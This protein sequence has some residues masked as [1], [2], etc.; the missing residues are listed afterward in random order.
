[1]LAY[2]G[3]ADDI[4]ARMRIHLRSESKDFFDRVVFLVSS[5]EMLT[6]G[7]VRYLESRLIKL[8]QEA[9]SVALTIGSGVSS[10]AAWSGNTITFVDTDSVSWVFKR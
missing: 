4:A 3:E 2:I 5:D 6:K 9:G 1:M 7:H 8:T 10:L